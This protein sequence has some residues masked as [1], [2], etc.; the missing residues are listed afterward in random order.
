MHFWPVSVG[1]KGRIRTATWT[2]LDDWL[3]VDAVLDDALVEV[4]SGVDC[5]TCIVL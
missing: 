1:R 3:D 2:L 5:N 4:A